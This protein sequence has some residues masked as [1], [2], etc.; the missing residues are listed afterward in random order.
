MPRSIAALVAAVVV[1]LA[2]LT[3]V[4]A[5]DAGTTITPSAGKY[6]G[7]D[8]HDHFVSMHLHSG[9][10]VHFEVEHVSKDFPEVTIQGHNIHHTCSNHWCVR[11]QWTHDNEVTG[12]WNNSKT[13][14]KGTFTVNEVAAR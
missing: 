12:E 10:V 1:A 14:A 5:A 6:I 13:G 9:K 3:A 2:S 4:G 8:N 7:R 11:G